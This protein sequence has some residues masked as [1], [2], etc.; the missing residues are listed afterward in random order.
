MLLL[1][2]EPIGEPVARRGPFVMNTDE[3]IQQAIDDYRNGRLVGG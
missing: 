1:S 3:E 2:G